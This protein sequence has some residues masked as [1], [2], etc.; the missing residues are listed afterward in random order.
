[1]TTEAFVLGGGGG[2]ELGVPAWMGPRVQN[3]VNGRRTPCLGPWGRR[4]QA[5]IL[6][7]GV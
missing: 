3:K 7:R 5:A 6:Q 4:G 1:M 2:A